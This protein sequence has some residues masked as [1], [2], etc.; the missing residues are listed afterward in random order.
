MV[1]VAW[2]FFRAESVTEA[3]GYLERMTSNFELRYGFGLNS[4][5]ESLFVLAV[6]ITSEVFVLK[7]KSIP[8]FKYAYWIG[9]TLFIIHFYGDQRQFIYFEF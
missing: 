2:V 8:L 7:N 9:I 1:C 4:I 6:L 3:V 5:M